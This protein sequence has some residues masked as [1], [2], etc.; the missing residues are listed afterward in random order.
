LSRAHST[1]SPGQ[2]GLQELLKRNKEWASEL[3]KKDPEFFNEL[4]KTQTPEVLWIGNASLLSNAISA[5][6]SKL[7][8]RVL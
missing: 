5:S 3:K 8:K 4:A 7:A 1:F 2:Q 6:N